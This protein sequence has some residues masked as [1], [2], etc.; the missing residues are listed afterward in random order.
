[1]NPGTVHFDVLSQPLLG[2]KAAAGFHESC[3][4]L[5]AGAVLARHGAKEIALGCV[6]GVIP[7][8]FATEGLKEPSSFHGL[9]EKLAMEA[10]LW[11]VLYLPLAKATLKLFW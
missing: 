3:L 1:M 4:L 5:T 6:E 8:Y 9:D 7:L 10:E 11:E 2:A